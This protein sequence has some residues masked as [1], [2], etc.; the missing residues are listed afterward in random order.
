[1]VFFLQF[2]A[3]FLQRHFHGVTTL[4]FFNGKLADKGTRH[5]GSKEYLK[6]ALGEW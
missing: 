3:F 5:L 4:P 2:L 6:A 1:L